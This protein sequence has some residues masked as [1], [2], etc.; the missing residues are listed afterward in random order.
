VTAG[1]HQERQDAVADFVRDVA[2]LLDTYC[3]TCHADADADET[4]TF[5][6]ATASDVAETL[7]VNRVLF[8]KMS[9][10]LKAKR[11]PPPDHPQPDPDERL[12]L[13][14]WLDHDVLAIDCSVRQDPGRVTARRLNRV[15]YT[16]TIRDLLSLD[17]FRIAE[18]FPPDDSGYGFDN[19]GDVLRMSPILLERYLEAAEE[20]L[21]LAT[22]SRHASAKLREPVG[23]LKLTF[24][25]RQEYPRL[26]P[27][28]RS[29]MI[30]HSASA[31]CTR[32]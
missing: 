22:K 19:N 31:R 30:V 16:N 25:N 14:D 6:F 3:V 27:Y 28:L 26:M 2:P 23:D 20:A 18:S 12:L 10:H 11:M 24:Y 15:E 21:R 1:A 9:L 8:E 29:P 17:D 7:R 4:P 5:A 32:I 13:I